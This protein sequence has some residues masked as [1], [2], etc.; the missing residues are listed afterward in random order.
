MSSN[1][2]NLTAI[3]ELHLEAAERLQAQASESKVGGVT[4]GGSGEG[5]GGGDVCADVD[6]VDIGMCTIS[7]ILTAMVW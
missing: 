1:T 3:D 6:Y 5:G 4:E 7:V 2:F